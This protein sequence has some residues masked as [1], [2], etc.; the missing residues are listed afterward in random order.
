V[1]KFAEHNTIPVGSSKQVPA[2]FFMTLE[3]NG[4]K[5]HLSSPSCQDQ[6][7]LKL[8]S[9]VLNLLIVGAVGTFLTAFKP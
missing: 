5:L 8:M 7:S 2:R 6:T 9:T 4:D 1:L 3:V